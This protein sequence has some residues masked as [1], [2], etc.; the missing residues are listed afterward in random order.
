M[1]ELKYLLSRE[2]LESKAPATAFKELADILFSC[3]VIRKGDRTYHLTDVEFYLYDN[4]HRD[5]ITYPRNCP[6][7][8]WFF[9]ASGVDI[10]FESHIN[11][12]EGVQKPI[13]TQEAFFGGILIRGIEKIVQGGTNVIFDGPMKAME[14]L[15]DQFDAFGEVPDF[16]KL[17]S[18][19]P[20]SALICAPTMR[21]GLERDSAKKVHNIL[22]YNYSGIEDVTEETLQLEYAHY[23]DAKYRYIRSR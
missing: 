18:C 1:A 12:R 16:P 17:E 2:S 11:L 4:S 19:A 21:H 10:S 22:A 13:L 6:A 8:Y 7:G 23:L 9:H 14:E 20:I 15:F 3:F 5:I